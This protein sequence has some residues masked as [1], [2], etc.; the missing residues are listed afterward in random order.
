MF[1]FVKYTGLNF[2]E[3]GNSIMW[4]LMFLYLF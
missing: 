2:L 4:L 1:A 3:Y